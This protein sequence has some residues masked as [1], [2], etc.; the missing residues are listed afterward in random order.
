MRK[1]KEV[2]DLLFHVPSVALKGSCAD[3]EV[4]IESHAFESWK[5]K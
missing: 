5:Q 4:L 2:V 3:M 1:R